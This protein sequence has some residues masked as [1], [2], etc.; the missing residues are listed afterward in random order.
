MADDTRKVQLKSEFD[1]SGVRKGTDEAK[2]ALQ[3]L[4]RTAQT[5]GQAAS[6]GVRKIGDGA[7]DAAAKLDRG[8]KSIISSIQRVSAQMSA[9]E[10]N[11][12]GYFEALANQRGA[13]LTALKPYL[14]DL[15][16]AEDAQRKAAGTLNLVGQSAAQT[17][18]ALRILPAQLTDVAT[19]LAGGQSPFLV[20]LQQGGQV[21]DSFGG[22]GNASKVLLSFVTPLRLALGGAAG[23][24][25]ALALAYNQGAEEGKA[26]ERAII[27]SGN[28]A[29]TTRDQ[30]S[31][32]AAAI[33]KSVG[34]QGQAA[35]ALA[36]LATSGRVASASL[37]L[38]AEAAV[39]LEREGVQA[40]GKTV[41]AF[42]E[43]GKDP[44]AAS[45][46]LNESTNFLTLTVLKQIKAL[47]D[48]GKAA[49]AAALAQEAYATSAISRTKDLEASLGV[50]EKA[51]R[52][53][54]G[55]A[56]AAWDEMVG[57]GRPTTISDQLAEAGAKVDRLRDN[58][59]RRGSER[60]GL[61]DNTGRLQAALDEQAAVQ[62]LQRTL[63]K[64]VELQAQQTAAVRA[65]VDFQKLQEQ[66]LTKQQ[67]LH[68]EIKKARELAETSGA[69]PQDLE[70]VLAGIR[71]KYKEVGKS[72]LTDQLAAFKAT[73]GVLDQLTK[74]SLDTLNSEATRGL[75]TQRE[76]I[77]GRTALELQANERRGELL[78]EELAL[79]NRTA[80]AEKERID[81]AARLGVVAAESVGIRL[82]GENDVLELLYRQAQASR[83]VIEAQR[84]EIQRDILAEQS[85]SD[86]SRLAA[87]NQVEAYVD[88]IK[89]SIEATQFEMSLA[90]V[91]EQQRAIRLEQF[92][93]EIQRRREIAALEA[94][95]D[96]NPFERERAAA[97]INE[98]ATRASAQAAAKITEDAFTQTNRNIS[99]GLADAIING[100]RSAADYLKNLFRQLVLQPVVSAA[101]QPLVGQ[102]Q[103]LLGGQGGG[104]SAGQLQNAQGLYSAGTKLWDGFNSGFSSV[105]DFF[106]FGG[107]AAAGT[108]SFGAGALSAAG[109]EAGGA[110]LTG[111]LAGY[112]GLG[113]ASFSSSLG[114]SAIFDAA[115][116]SGA[117]AGAAAAASSAASWIPIVG[118]AYAAFTAGSGFYKEGFSKATLDSK[119]LER[120]TPAAVQTDILKALGVSDK[121][122]NILSS[123]SGLGKLFG[124]S[125]ARVEGQS[126]SGNFS[127]SG[128][129]SGNVV[130]DLLSKGGIF[131]SDKRTQDIQAITGDLDLALDQGAKAI[132]Q[133]AQRFGE[134]LGL[135]VEKLA[136]VTSK[137]SVEISS[138]EVD[139]LAKKYGQAL[140]LPFDQ[141]SEAARKIVGTNEYAD[142][143]AKDA[144]RNADA[145]N[146]ALEIFGGALLDSFIPDIAPFK[147]AGES[148][149]DTIK[150]LGTALSQVNPLFSQLG[151]TLFDASLAGGQAAAQLADAFGGLNN[152]GQVAGQYYAA[153]YTE[154]ERAAKAT[155]DIADTLARVG[156]ALPATRDEFRKIVEAQDLTTESG[157]AAFAALLQVNGAFAELV[158]AATAAAVAITDVI[159]NV[160]SKELSNAIDGNIGKFLTESQ[161]TARAYSTIATNLQG[162][163][164]AV[165]VGGLIGLSKA[166]ILEFAQAFVLAGTNSE[167]AKIAVV[168]AAGA[169][170]DLKDQAA[171]ANA[172]L[173][174]QLQQSIEGNVDKFLTPRQ[175]VERQAAGISGNLASVGVNFSPEQLLSATRQQI[176]DFARSFVF[177]ADKSTEAKIAVVDAAGALEGL[178]Q[179]LAQL[180]LDD[181]LTGLGVSASELMGAYRE[182]RPEADNLVVAY[183]KT[184]TEVQSLSSALD[185]LAGTAALSAL[186][187][188]RATVAQR[189]AL[190]GVIT[191]NSNRAFDL[192]VGQG[193]Q[194]ALDLL[195]SR[196]ADLWRQFASTSSPEV[197]QA[198]TDITLQ[199]IDLEGQL[200]AQ[201]N[202]SQIDALRQQITAAERLRDVA[203]Q[204]GGFILQLKAGDLSNLSATGRLDAQRSLFADSLASGVDVQ[205]NAQALL[206]QA[207]QTFG[208]ST[209]QY[210]AIF[211][212]TT[213]KLAALGLSG[214]GAGATISDAQRQI[215]ALT[216]VSNT[217]ER[218]A[219]ALGELNASFGINLGTLNTSV[220]QQLQV[221]RDT[222]ATLQATLANQE[223]QILQ[224]GEYYQRSVTALE[225]MAA[226]VNTSPLDLALAESQP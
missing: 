140:S 18:A 79:A 117:E 22:I 36:Q 89:A 37:A 186:D 112:S 64:N 90:G 124:R 57:I 177:A 139:A 30:L 156:I 134:A 15:K 115:A 77:E 126:I 201:A 55:A 155:D 122:A 2:G 7:D 131:R 137:I 6:D 181:F 81:L 104:G 51:W 207:Q 189:N 34:T 47:E 196:E 217:A 148:T 92:R 91:S 165:D 24:A 116:T 61:N 93:I 154:A 136:G 199:R 118:W 133:T 45:I 221:Q 138:S 175:R 17:S 171:A 31:G 80:G 82:R 168:N 159:T 180:Q 78:R 178:A 209:G 203:A 176:F 96:L 198:I 42:A 67:R 111:G 144:Q 128:D 97:K 142:A 211:E 23:A 29:G 166:Q 68:L 197:A 73:Q 173:E 25:V 183:Q 152:L 59:T 41:A 26:F 98:A 62:E 20:L 163:G 71:D 3:D 222:L 107:A 38:A 27:L 194:Q 210:S 219:T 46:K 143:V 149:T 5:S 102:A 35:D 153:Y 40:I 109:L 95:R 94:N 205:G 54:K 100:G 74:Q 224:A 146:R 130:T 113:G 114:S 195:R 170:A 158:P 72:V 84:E 164:V 32:M 190:Q 169:L 105:K 204:M 10:K 11:S 86:N 83:A 56:A 214:A 202:A 87:I 141:L 220:D 75:V 120:F 135:P 88:S 28:A 174:Q 162:A 145:V 33:G 188:L 147:N 103:S 151:L 218:Q 110:T 200:Q 106:G 119:F 12:A 223:A 13:N 129:F 85:R 208:G 213:A 52:G 43:L 226:A 21:K 44:L 121:L 127:G 206:R 108:G 70:K 99:D 157:R 161:R 14:E 65:G 8:T 63:R 58:R 4:A 187:Q 132:V 179:T 53:V 49:Q 19:S 123:A 160:I 1:A 69:K 66:S 76:F 225:T 191:G 212:D 101:I 216:N 172:A 50:L 9:G 39:R 48:E 193:G 167:N 192:R 215:D 185:E 182:L 150:R 16:K 125:A 60:S 184:K